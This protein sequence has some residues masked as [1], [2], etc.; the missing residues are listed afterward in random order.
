[1]A[2]A[3][4]TRVFGT[5]LEPASV[6][7]ATAAGS[8]CDGGGVGRDTAVAASALMLALFLLP[9]PASGIFGVGDNRRLD[10][11]GAMTS[12]C[13]P[14][15]WVARGWHEAG[16]LRVAASFRPRCGTVGGLA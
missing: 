4:G 2:L 9:P 15:V 6:A 16:S 7:D 3:D 10:A 5:R 12:S 14:Q 8:T 13:P 11:C 1:M